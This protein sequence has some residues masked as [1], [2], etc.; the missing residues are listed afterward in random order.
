MDH[1]AMN[2]ILRLSNL[3]E[4]KLNVLG[5]LEP[6]ASRHRRMELGDLCDWMFQDGFL[7]AAF[8]DRE[9]SSSSIFEKPTSLIPSLKPTGG[10]YFSPLV[11]LDAD[12]NDI[13]QYYPQ[14][15]Q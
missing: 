3:L 14:W 7:Y 4:M 15:Y 10:V 1:Q 5:T 13:I 6:D 2:A 11:Q 12:E 8:K 9:S